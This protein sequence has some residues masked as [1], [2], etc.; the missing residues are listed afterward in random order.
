M[1]RLFLSGLSIL[2]PIGLLLAWNL[3]SSVQTNSTTSL[4]R[5]GARLTQAPPGK[6]RLF[7]VV[8]LLALSA[9]TMMTVLLSVQ[10]LALL[11]AKPIGLPRE[12]VFARLDLPSHLD[13]SRVAAELGALAEE[14]R[15][16]LGREAGFIGPTAAPFA[17]F[18][19]TLAPSGRPEEEA[20]DAFRHSVGGGLE[21][22][23]GL[24]LLKGRDP[25][26][27]PYG[28]ALRRGRCFIEPG[29]VDM[30]RRSVGE[31]PQSGPSAWRS[32]GVDSGRDRAGRP[33]P[34]EVATTRRRIS[35]FL[36]L[37]YRLESSF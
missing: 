13:E 21:G 8:G 16:R 22:T 7:H 20:V 33:T 27:A 4:S 24:R 25:I 1:E 23:L 18:A 17:N 37:R 34:R 6:A 35:T 5:G 28:Q 36:F 31:I 14:A 9:G 2:L 12:L 19:T 29:Y 11:I 10:S 3:W 30:G 15:T 32:R 26:Q